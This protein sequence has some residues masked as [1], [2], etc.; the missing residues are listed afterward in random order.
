MQGDS[1]KFK[2]INEAELKVIGQISMDIHLDGTAEICKLLISDNTM[3]PPV[4]LGRDVL[5]Q[6]GYRIVD[7]TEQSGLYHK[8]R[9]VADFKRRRIFRCRQE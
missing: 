6:F 7:T 9:G 8:R 1:R 3:Q 2:G 5:K 4:V